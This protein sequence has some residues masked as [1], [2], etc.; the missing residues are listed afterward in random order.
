MFIENILVFCVIAAQIVIRLE[1]DIDTVKH[2]RRSNL[3][4]QPLAAPHRANG[5]AVR[6]TKAKCREGSLPPR[7]VVLNADRCLSLRSQGVNLCY[8]L[9]TPRGKI[10]SK[11]SAIHDQNCRKLLQDIDA[12]RFL[13]DDCHGLEG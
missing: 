9:G 5:N 3:H 6:Q 12:E 8:I 13:F 4:H 1:K 7:T 10:F 11:V 2:R